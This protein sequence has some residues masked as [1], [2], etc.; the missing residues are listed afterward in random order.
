MNLTG[1]TLSDLGRTLQ[2][3]VDENEIRDLVARFSDTCILGN[4]DGFRE[5]WAEDGLWEIGAPFNARVEG[6][7]AIVDMLHRL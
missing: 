1:K 4:H 5:L 3:I 7:E 6:I 2:R